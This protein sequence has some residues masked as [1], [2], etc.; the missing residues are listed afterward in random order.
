[1]AMSNDEK[2]TVGVVRKNLRQKR[3]Y[4]LL[5]IQQTFTPWN[6]EAQLILCPS[7]QQVSRFLIKVIAQSALQRPETHLLE[8]ILWTQRDPL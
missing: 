4:S 2:R 5:N 1:M 7:V 8:R 3:E 6:P